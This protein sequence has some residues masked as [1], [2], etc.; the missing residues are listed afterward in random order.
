MLGAGAF[1]RASVLGLELV[2]VVAA[3]VSEGVVVVGL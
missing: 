3:V 2:V 1:V